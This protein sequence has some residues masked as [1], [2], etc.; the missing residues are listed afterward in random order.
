MTVGAPLAGKR[1]LIVDDVM[2]TGTSSGEAVEIIR[3]NGGHPIA[4]VIAFDRQEQGKDSV[5][6]AT[7]EFTRNYGIPVRAAGTFADL[8]KILEWAQSQLPDERSAKILDMIHDYRLRYG[9]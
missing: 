4:A 3:A 2:T 7:Q 8:I 1:V 6:S 5:L 9:A